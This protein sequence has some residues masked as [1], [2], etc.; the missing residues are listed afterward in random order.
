MDDFTGL[1]AISDQVHVKKDHIQ[2][3]IKQYIDI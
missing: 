3:K 2:H 1:F